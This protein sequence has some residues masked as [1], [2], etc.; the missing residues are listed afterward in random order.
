MS[1]N[2][3]F[4]INSPQK[5]GVVKMPFKTKPHLCNDG[6]YFPPKNVTFKPAENG[7]FVRSVSFK[8]QPLPPMENFSLDAMI[9]AGLP[10]EKVKTV[11]MEPSIGS[12][13]LLASME[14]LEQLN[15][16]EN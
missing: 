13:I 15:K 5:K 4:W 11:I 12:D 14:Q 6:C 3:A 16:K 7:V 10:L 9:K 8:E 1:L 2:A